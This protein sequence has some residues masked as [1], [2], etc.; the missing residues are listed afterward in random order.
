MRLSDEELRDVFSRAEEIQRSSR[1]VAAMRAEMEAVISAGEAVGLARPAL[2]RALRER[3]ELAD[4]P[5]AA[6]ARVFAQSTNGK[7]YVCPVIARCATGRGGV[8][9]P[10]RSSRLMPR[11]GK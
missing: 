3:L 10:V 2:E 8:R 6:G 4:A 7:Y 5:P 11:D 9:G 1:T